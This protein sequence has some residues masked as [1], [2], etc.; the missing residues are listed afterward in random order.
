MEVGSFFALPL[1]N[2]RR[3]VARNRLRVPT[4]RV[5]SPGNRRTRSRT[6]SGGA[7]QRKILKARANRNQRR[8]IGA[9]IAA[10]PVQPQTRILRCPYQVSAFRR[11]SLMLGLESRLD[12]LLPR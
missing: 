4:L 1:F 7:L 8:V 10:R 12:F 3:F 9:R 6:H 5:L 2:T 11:N